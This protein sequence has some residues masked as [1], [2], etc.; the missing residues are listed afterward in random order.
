MSSL[1]FPN[2]YIKDFYLLVG[3][4]EKMSKIKKYDFF[5]NDY[6]FGEKTFEQAEIKMQK[7]AIKNLITRNDL[8]EED[9]DCL[10]GGDL[11]NQISATS[12]SKD[13]NDISFLG[14]YSACATFVESL[15]ISSLLIEKSNIKNVIAITSSHNLTAER[16]FRYPVEYGALKS[17]TSTFTA[18]GACSALVVKEKAKIK[19]ESTTIG[20]V[21]N[22]GCNDVSNMGA[23]MAPAAGDTLHNHLKELKREIDYYDLIMTGDLGCI[24]SDIFKRYIKECYNLQIKNYIDAGCEIFIHDDITNSGGSGPVCLPLVFFGKIIDNKKYKRVLLI[25]TGSLHS[26]TMVNQKQSIPAIAHAISL[27]VL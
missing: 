11:L 23:I 9:I 20:K 1:F 3:P 21:I 10:I 22:L 8:K 15:I 19:I 2:A 27:E 7:L 13:N 5:L 17:K 18:T 16:Q 25:A 12:Y 26:T 24:G 4:L 14:V 6:Y